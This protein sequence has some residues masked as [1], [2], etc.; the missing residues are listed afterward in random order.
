MKTFKADD[1]EIISVDGRT[2]NTVMN[3]SR[4][5]ILISNIRATKGPNFLIPNTKKT[6]NH[7]WLAFIKTLIFQHFNLKSYIQIKTNTL[8]YVIDGMF[9]QFNLNFNILSN[10]LKK[11]NFD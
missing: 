8:G 10:N 7:L 3:L 6:F 9:S 4:N 1:N 2:N 11:S 5:L